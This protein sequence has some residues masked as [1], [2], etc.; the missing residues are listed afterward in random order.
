LQEL[1][2]VCREYLIGL[3]LEIERRRLEKQGPST[4]K[5]QLELAAY[6]T[7]CR[8][9]PAHLQ[10]ALRLAMTTFVKA[11]NYPTAAS[12]ATKLLELGPAPPV[13]T[14]AKNLLATANKNPRDTVEIEYDLH[15]QFDICPASLTPIYSNQPAVDDPFTGARYH[16]RYAGSV[17]VVS[18]VTEVGKRGQGLQSMV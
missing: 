10:L 7:H 9:Q 13:V 6:F 12:F 14:Q 4:L 17:C 2:V 11:K 15:S 8:L 5:R 18:G 3:S 16:E 1:I